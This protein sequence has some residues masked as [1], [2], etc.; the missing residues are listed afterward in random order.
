MT[1]EMCFV[2][3]KC[4]VDCV[5]SHVRR[6]YTNQQT[7]L[8]PSVTPRRSVSAV[9]TDVE[10]ADAVR[11]IASFNTIVEPR[12]LLNC[13]LYPTQPRLPSKDANAFNVGHLSAFCAAKRT[14]AAE[15]S[16]D[17]L[18]RMMTAASPGQVIDAVTLKGAA[19]SGVYAADWQRL[20]RMAL[21]HT[22]R[23]MSARARHD[24]A[25]LRVAPPD[26][27]RS[28]R[29]PGRFN[30]SRQKSSNPPRTTTGADEFRDGAGRKLLFLPSVEHPAWSLH[31]EGVNDN[32][33]SVRCDAT[34]RSLRDAR[35]QELVVESN[36]FANSGTSKAIYDCGGQLEIGVTHK[37][38]ARGAAIVDLSRL[39][40]VSFSRFF[41][42]RTVANERLPMSE[43]MVTR[44][45]VLPPNVR[46]FTVANRSA[47]Q[48]INES[49]AAVVEYLD[50]FAR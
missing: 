7:A 20:I 18:S 21:D 4:I 50:V 17:L 1:C 46:K 47:A 45:P 37:S 36:R 34:G 26:V 8:K 25:M 44:Q 49:I 32:F 6:Q 43:A 9:P 30:S 35:Q 14:S 13:H 16:H 33:D 39:D 22:Q 29:A 38:V 11:C 42:E 10:C 28:A 3:M 19:S 48:R 12:S 24:S 40:S 23:A 27:P 31:A 15:F 5:M 2:W 41:S